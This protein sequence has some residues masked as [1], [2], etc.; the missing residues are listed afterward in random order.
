MF[1]VLRILALL[2]PC[3]A[4][5]GFCPVAE[6]APRGLFG[7][8]GP[9][10][11]AASSLREVAQGLDAQWQAQGN[12]AL[13]I[14]IASSGDLAR[15]IVAGAGADLV[16]LADTEWMAELA[17]KSF[18]HEGSAAVF[19]RGGLCIVAPRDAENETP[20][21]VERLTE[22]DHL[23]PLPS[24]LAVPLGRYARAWLT[25]I[26]LWQELRS[27]VTTVS[28]ARSALAAVE[29]GAA[30]FGIVYVADAQR[31]SA[32]DV[33]YTV[34]MDPAIRVEAAVGVP[35]NSTVEGSGTR[36]RAMLL[37]PGGFDAIQAAGL[38]PFQRE[39]PSGEAA[40]NDVRASQASV[41]G[42][43]LWVSAKVA[44][45]VVILDF[46]PALLI[47]WVLA[48]RRFWGRSVLEA[49]VHMP[50]I[51]PPTA[52]G[53]LL[54]LALGTDGPLGAWDLLLTFQGAVLAA[55][56]VA[57]PLFV[58]PMRAALEGVDPRLE[59]MARTLGCGPFKAFVTVTLPLASR[60]IGAGV[61][62]GMGRALGEFGATILVAGSLLGETQTLSMAIFEAYQLHDDGGALR[63]VGVCG[64]VAFGIVFCADRLSY[65]GSSRTGGM[66]P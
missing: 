42:P 31:S 60:G 30:P 45:A 44:L 20:F 41:L 57:F 52:V 38:D 1:F 3:T 13:Q 26:G 35:V 66:R 56:V 2:V 54:L 53:W 17:G 39:L 59:A 61:L 14:S 37:G 15:Q 6:S 49:V 4:L 63:L 22:G 7:A 23:L 33:L 43:V 11:L 34:P 65:S 48:R 25:K 12:S 55:G 24:T 29:A 27:R 46:F 16:L 36:L 5:L 50:L 47:A 40:S 51:L 28:D 19:A 21:H 10:V 32:V 18:L 62:L 64:L 58:R 9:R 8:Q